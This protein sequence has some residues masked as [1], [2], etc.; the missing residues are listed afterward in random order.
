MAA[1][2]PAL[3][4]AAAAQRQAALTLHATSPSA[5]HIWH[6][7]LPAG[8]ALPCLPRTR[9]LRDI[10]KKPKK[11]EAKQ[12]DPN[13]ILDAGRTRNGCANGGQPAAAAAAG[14]AG[15]QQAAEE[16]E[17]QGGWHDASSSGWSEQELR[18][19]A[20]R[21]QR[22]WARLVRDGHVPPFIVQWVHYCQSVPA[23]VVPD[24]VS[25][26]RLIH[27]GCGVGSIAPAPAAATDA[28]AAA[29]PAAKG[30][31]APAAPLMAAEE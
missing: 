30:Q 19:M 23:G 31:V 10:T 8:P 7:Q 15:E 3:L 12:L 22:E 29:A 6:K 28:A 4:L 9:T 17:E 5:C 13:C 21:K 24:Y 14:V 27:W 11:N 2:V 18:A 25:L 20:T 26:H 16:E 1:A